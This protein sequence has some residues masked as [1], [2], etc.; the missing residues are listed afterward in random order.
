M[1]MFFLFIL[2]E[3]I[4]IIFGKRWVFIGWVGGF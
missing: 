2:Y 4:F 1:I 3:V